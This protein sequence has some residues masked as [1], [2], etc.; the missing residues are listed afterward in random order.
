MG[1]G[2]PL[3]DLPEPID[4][5][6]TRGRPRAAVRDEAWV[7]MLP[8]VRPSGAEADLWG[9]RSGNVIRAMSLVPDAVRDLKTLSTAHY[10]APDEVMDPSVSRTLDRTQIELLAGR[11]SALNECFY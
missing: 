8:N 3:H 9:P 5:E 6:P 10:V 2:V 11:V 4:G 1:I 7:P